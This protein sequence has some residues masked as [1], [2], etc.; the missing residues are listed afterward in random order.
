MIAAPRARP[1][2]A[3]GPGRA[4]A[5]RRED[6]RR[7]AAAA[8]RGRA[9]GGDGGA[10]RARAPA[11]RAWRGL[12]AV[13]PGGAGRRARESTGG[14]R[15]GRTC[16]SSARRNGRRRRPSALWVDDAQSMDYR[17]ARPATRR[18][19]RSSGRALLALALAVLLIK[20]GERVGLMGTDG[21]AAARRARAAEP[22]G[23][24]AGG[25]PREDRPDYGAPPPTGMPPRLARVFFSDFLGD[26]EALMPALAH[27][28]DRGIKGCFVQV[29]DAS[30]EAFPFDGRAIFESMGGGTEFETQRARALREAYS[31]GWPSGGRGLR[32]SAAQAR[33][34]LPRSTTPASRRA[35]RCSGST[36]RSGTGPDADARARWASS[37]PGCCW[38]WWRCRSCGGSC[39]RCRRRRCGG[40]S[41]ACGC[42]SG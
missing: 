32:D 15:A 7:P 14:A 38:R 41:R 11:R 8:G 36:W 9:S 30:E 10:G 26:P 18:A 20:A 19:R 22:H 6:R 40:G 13:P 33:L 12:L 39:G 1:G 17:D 35:R 42:C 24:G 25:E 28:A 34:A 31:R 37:R 29:L 21:R 5:R 27:A 23:A 4:A 16:S 2:Q 3:A